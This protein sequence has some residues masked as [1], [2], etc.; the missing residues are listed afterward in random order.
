[1]QIAEYYQV[2]QHVKTVGETDYYAA[3]DL[4]TDSP[5]MLRVIDTSKQGAVGIGLEHLAA[6]KLKRKM[7]NE[8]K[9]LSQIQG[10]LTV[11]DVGF[12]APYYYH[13]YPPFEFVNLQM[14]G[15]IS[16][17]AL[18][19]IALEAAQTLHNLHVMGIVHCDVS[20]EN[21]LLID[22]H[23]RL[24]EFTIANHEQSEGV[25][26]GNPPYMSPESITGAPPAPARD[27]WGLGVTLYYALSGAL[28]FGDIELPREVG[29]PRLFKKIMTESPP[30]LADETWQLII[31]AMLEKDPK[32]R[33]TLPALI[34]R[35]EAIS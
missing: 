8:A 10:V 34:Q 26:P 7:E 17:D 4:R 28:P 1:M 21:I 9:I 23:V 6:D 24:I 30:P 15:K 5:I 31:S 18:R 20:A 29:A 27:V 11:L 25:A 16:P 14:H 3:I 32:N 12:D 22:N 35:I 19:L 13:V 2:M 33:I